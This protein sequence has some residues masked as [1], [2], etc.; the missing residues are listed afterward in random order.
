MQKRRTYKRKTEI[1]INKANIEELQELS[2]SREE[3]TAE[4]HN[5]I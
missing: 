1:N 2:R 4:E 5:K 3:S